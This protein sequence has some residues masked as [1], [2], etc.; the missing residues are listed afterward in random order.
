MN[1]IVPKCSINVEW[2]N[3]SDN[4][5]YTIKFN[6]QTNVKLLI[7]IPGMLAIMICFE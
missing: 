4:F 1:N 2:V 7:R 5:S 6:G 3:Q